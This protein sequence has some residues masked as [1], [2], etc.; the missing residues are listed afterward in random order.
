MWY[1][2]AYTDRYQVPSDPRTWVDTPFPNFHEHFN[3]NSLQPFVE[4][5]FRVAPRLSLTPGIKLADYAMYLNQYADNGSTIGC[6]GGKL[7]G[8]AG[9]AS[10]LCVGGVQFVTHGT[11]YSSWLPSLDGRYFLRDNWSVYAQYATGSVIPPSGVFDTTS[12]SVAVFPKPTVARTYQ[13]G[14]VWKLNRLTLDFD[15]YYSHFQNTYTMTTDTAGEAVWSLPGASNTKGMEA[16]A[17]A[18]V[19]HGFNVYLNGTAGNAKYAQR[20]L[21]VANAPSNTATAGLMYQHANWDAAFFSK[22]IGPMWNDAGKGNTLFNQA[23]PI[24]PFNMTNV[25]VNYTVKGASALR[26]TKLRLSVNNL[27]DKHSIVG[28][29]PVNVAQHPTPAGGDTL[30]LLPGRSVMLTVQFGFAPP[31]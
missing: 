28:V 9:S 29:A 15:A 2:W 20:G 6:P 11:N 23:V 8:K 19:G 16:E 18:F 24:D 5:E 22:R 25:F 1:E 7:S 4:Y 30:T 14:S 10:T 13:V 21:W 17:N 3:T 31:R 26:G 27:L 12:A